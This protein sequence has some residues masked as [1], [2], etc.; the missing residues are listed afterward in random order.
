MRLENSFNASDLNGIEKHPNS[1]DIYRSIFMNANDAIFLMKENII[2]DCNPK[3]LELFDRTREEIINKNPSEFSPEF[4]TSQKTSNLLIE[5]KISKVQKG[6]SLVFPWKHTRGNGEIFE[7]EVSLN[8]VNLENEELIIALVRDVSDRKITELHL[9]ESENRYKNLIEKSPDA[10]LIQRND[11]VLYVNPAAVKLSGLQTKDDLIGLNIYDFIH[12]DLKEIVRSRIEYSLKEK[13]EIERIELKLLNVEKELVYV[14]ASFSPIFYK[15]ELSTIHFLRNITE[16][17]IAHDALK[18]HQRMLTTLIS[19]LPGIVYRCLNDENYTMK[20]ISEGISSLTGYRPD[21]FIDNKTLAYADI[22]APKDLAKC[23][24]AI[25]ESL[26]KKL[27]FEIMY[28]VITKDGVQKDVWERGSGIFI[29]DK[30][31]AIEGFITDITEQ[32]KA[33]VAL[34]ESEERFRSLFINSTMG[35]YRTS[36]EGEIY[37][38]N[39]AVI[40]MMGY[41]SF[42]DISRVNSKS[43]YAKENGREEMLELLSERGEVLGYESAWKKKNGETLFVRESA[44]A[45]KDEKGNIQFIEGVVEDITDRKLAEESLLETN[46]L[47]EKTFASLGEAV[48][49][50]KYPESKVLVCNPAVKDI[51]G[52]SRAEL[53]GH[54]TEI[55]HVNDEYFEKF[56][57]IVKRHLTKEKFFQFEYKMKQK[58]GNIIITENTITTLFD[59]KGWQEGVISV[60]RDITHRK[61]AEINLIK[62]KKLAEQSDRLKSEFLAQMSHEIRTPINAILSFAGLLREELEDKVNDDLK[63]S[64]DIMSRAGN[65]IIRTIDLILNMAEVQTGT[66]DFVPRKFDLCEEILESLFLSFKPSAKAKSI[67]LVLTKEAEDCEVTADEYTAAQIFS[68]LIDNAIKFTKSGAVEIKILRN[69][70]NDLTVEVID[71]GIGIREEYLP[72]IFLPFTQEEQGYTRKFE[73]SGLGLA[74]VKKYCDLNNATLLVDSKK[75]KGTKFTI[76]FP[77]LMK[78]D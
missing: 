38:A 18:E 67:D 39:P 6:E 53:V 23:R 60:V 4:Q 54:S 70:D 22:I 26:K 49:I 36:V 10:I 48:F 37:M 75:E 50:L 78:A 42:E 55:L 8:L 13:E 2:I 45:I 64:F 21:E 17:K 32:K 9:S 46:N 3:T 20:F 73:G 31:E 35:I 76:I 15:G 63:T 56:G 40:K 69:D 66:Y 41:E 74:L 11:K 33:E 1:K 34:R 77:K 58:D 61:A 7:A 5:E 65:R 62:A 71:S 72:Q 12:P 52:Y 68:N 19:N 29:D 51:F 16:S 44:R 59:D 14:E 47:L 25:D 28:K 43:A 30:L 57:L 27:P 24:I